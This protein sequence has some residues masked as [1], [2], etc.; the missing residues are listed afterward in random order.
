MN[1][2]QFN[3]KLLEILICPRSGGKLSFDKE[4]GLLVTK[5]GKFS[6]KIIKGIPKLIL[7]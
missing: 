5:D 2:E 7:D 4:K 6:Y 1:D 3:E